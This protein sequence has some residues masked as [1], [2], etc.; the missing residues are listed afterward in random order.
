MKPLLKSKMQ[1]IEAGSSDPG[2]CYIM[3]AV[4][5][6]VVGDIVGQIYLSSCLQTAVL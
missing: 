2:N 6:V 3:A 4:I 1:S 5:S